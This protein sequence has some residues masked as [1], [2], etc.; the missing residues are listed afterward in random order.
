MM[1]ALEFQNPIEQFNE[2]AGLQYTSYAEKLDVPL[3]T[4]K[5]WFENKKYPP[6]WVQKLV[7]KTMSES[8]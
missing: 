7:I 1:V 5:S 6:V 2:Y 8:F 4:V 3:E